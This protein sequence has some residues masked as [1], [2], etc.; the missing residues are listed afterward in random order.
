MNVGQILDV[1]FTY[2][3]ISDIKMEFVGYRVEMRPA[4]IPDF[5]S[6]CDSKLQ[7][8][9]YDVICSGHFCDAKSQNHAS[10][11]TSRCSTSL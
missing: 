2:T 8:V 5:C 1:N 9:P 4:K 7:V 10:I 3:T 6:V 11:S